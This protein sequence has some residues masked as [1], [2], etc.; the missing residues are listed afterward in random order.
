MYTFG[1]ICFVN[2]DWAL[3]ALPHEL[4]H[5]FGLAHWDSPVMRPDGWEVTPGPL[6]AVA[7]RRA[8]GY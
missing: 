1:S 3:E 4:G 5:A 2:D 6:D 7:V 8:H